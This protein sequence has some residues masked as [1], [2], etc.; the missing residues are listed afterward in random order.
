VNLQLIY[1]RPNYAY[2]RTRLENGP[3]MRLLKA[4]EDTLTVPD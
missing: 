1:Q 3:V 2:S 4:A